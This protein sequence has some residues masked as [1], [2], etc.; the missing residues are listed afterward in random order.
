MSARR[1][2]SIRAAQK[3]ARRV[4]QDPQVAGIRFGILG[5]RETSTGECVRRA[6]NE[7]L[8]Q[9]LARTLVA[10]LN[11]L[12]VTRIV[13]CDPHAFNTL[14]NEYPEFGGHYEVVHHTQLIAR[15][16]PRAASASTGLRARDLSRAV[17]PRPAQRGIRGAARDHRA[18]DHGTRRSNSSFGAKRRCAAAPAAGACGWTRRSVAGSTSCASSRRCRR[19]PTYRDG[20]SLL[21]DDDERRHEGARPRDRKS[22]RATSP[23]SSPT[24]LQDVKLV[25]AAASGVGGGSTG[26]G[27]AAFSRSAG[28]QIPSFFSYV[29]LGATRSCSSTT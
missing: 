27:D 28:V 14:R 24:R 7:M 16:S 4:R 19:L 1:N 22:P 20:L 25:D 17:L 11:G 10:T 2:R 5:A 3:I 12:G 15:L 9:Q 18:A 23:S 29:D 26:H 13:T 8:F 6:G 21:R